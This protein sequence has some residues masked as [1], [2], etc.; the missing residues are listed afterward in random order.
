MTGLSI[1]GLPAGEYYVVAGG[2]KVGAVSGSRIQVLSLPVSGT[3]V[4]VEVNK[5]K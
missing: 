1:E 5:L 4:K 3:A 2:E